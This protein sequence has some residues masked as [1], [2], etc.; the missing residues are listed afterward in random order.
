MYKSR[1]C[2][3]ARMNREFKITIINVNKY[4]NNLKTTQRNKQLRKLKNFKMTRKQK[5]EADLND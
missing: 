3:D 1:T 4:F 2:Q 5:H